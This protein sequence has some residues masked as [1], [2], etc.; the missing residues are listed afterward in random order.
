MP[1]LPSELAQ[2]LRNRPARG[3]GP[4]LLTAGGVAAAFAVASCCGL[5]LLMAGLGMGTVWLSGVALLA[6][7]YRV[8]LLGAA[9]LALGAAAILLWRQRIACAP[10]SICARPAVRALTLAGLVVGLVLL[11][12][13]YAY[14]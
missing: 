9:T 4:V 3:A 7:P 11:Y 1:E 8:L 14:A 2:G 6:G 10:G 12:L 5:P 13:G